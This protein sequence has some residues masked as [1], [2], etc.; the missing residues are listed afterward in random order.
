MV[1]SSERLHQFISA[2]TDPKHAAAAIIP[3]CEVIIVILIQ[4]MEEETTESIS[5]PGLI[6]ADFFKFDQ[7]VVI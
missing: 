5:M 2:N 7:K 4:D 3:T 1:M 6:P